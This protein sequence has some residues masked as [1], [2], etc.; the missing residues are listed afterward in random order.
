MQ[1]WGWRA[2]GYD[3]QA[4]RV[5]RQAPGG[6]SASI[7]RAPRKE[8]RPNGPHSLPPSPNTLIIETFRS[9]RHHRDSITREDSRNRIYSS[10]K[11]T[12]TLSRNASFYCRAYCYLGNRLYYLSSAR[13]QAS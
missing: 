3:I 2:R 5:I 12:S 1:K 13:V 9:E 7:D 8:S 4:E 10:A 11:L 6:C